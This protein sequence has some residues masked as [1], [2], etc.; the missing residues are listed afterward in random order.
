[1]RLSVKARIAA[2]TT[3]ILIANLATAVVTWSYLSRASEYGAIAHATTERAQRAVLAAQRVSEFMG[4]AENLVFSFGLEGRPD[5]TSA[6]Y[7]TLMGTD[8][9]ATTA[10]GAIAKP[11]SGAGAAEKWDALR[12]ATYDWV[13][14]EAAAAGSSLRITRAADGRYR[15][16]VDTNLPVV[17][18]LVG[19]S[20][21]EMMQAVRR[22]GDQLRNGYLRLYV[23]QAQQEARAAATAE[24]QARSQAALTIVVLLT[25]SFAIA[26]VSAIWLY[27]TIVRPLNRARAF[28]DAV[29]GGN[30][31]LEYADHTEDEIGVLTRAVENMAH[32]VAQKIAIMREMAG[33][34]LVTAEGVSASA[35][36]A[37][38]SAGALA[39]GSDPV[40]AD[41]RDVVEQAHVLEDIARQM[42]EA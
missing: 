40:I 3:I 23:N 42:L 15:G 10:I 27:R 33:V 6:A 41:S 29:A 1:M 24:A 35:E 9:T 11:T 19:L 25:A 7:G 26:G 14:S 34:V 39:D 22:Q 31:D 16:G 2:A 4:E 18:E 13:N 28:A 21:P 30:M 12:L 8:R 32:A 36:H 37:L 5:I 38:A 20:R 17:R